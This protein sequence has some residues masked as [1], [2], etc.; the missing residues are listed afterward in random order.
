[1][2]R[3]PGAADIQVVMNQVCLWYNHEHGIFLA[4]LSPANRSIGRRKDVE[5]EVNVFENQ[6]KIGHLGR[7][8]FAAPAFDHDPADQHDHDPSVHG[9]AYCALCFA[10]A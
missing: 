8:L 5:Q 2:Q 4:A 1:M 3:K 10:R 9:S 6:H 7:N